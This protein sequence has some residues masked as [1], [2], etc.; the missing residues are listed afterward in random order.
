VDNSFGHKTTK[1]RSEKTKISDATAKWTITKE[2]KK[3][4]AKEDTPAKNYCTGNNCKIHSQIRSSPPFLI[5]SI[6]LKLPEDIFI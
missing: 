1:C 5:S 6:N 4:S 2:A 3:Y